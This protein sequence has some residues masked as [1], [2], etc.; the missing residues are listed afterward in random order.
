M[1]VTAN[2]MRE[3]HECIESTEQYEQRD[4]CVAAV[5]QQAQLVINERL[6]TPDPLITQTI[7]YTDSH[8]NFEIPI[9]S[10]IYR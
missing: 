5:I 2:A 10:D 8:S 4:R 1:G 3:G 7:R 9:F 6:L